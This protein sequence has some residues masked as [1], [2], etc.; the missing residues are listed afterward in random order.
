MTVAELVS[1]RGGFGLN[2]WERLN[3][4]IEEI[5][6]GPPEASIAF[7]EE[8]M[9][10]IS[11]EDL[12]LFLAGL[13]AS[14]GDILTTLMELQTLESVRAFI[15]NYVKTFY[16][17]F[18]G[19]ETLV[20]YNYSNPDYW[21]LGLIIEQASGMPF[22]EYIM[23][24][25]FEPLGMTNSGFLGISEASHRYNIHGEII[26]SE[27]VFTL[28]FATGGLVSTIYDL[29]IWLDAYFN[30]E[31]FDITRLDEIDN[32]TYNYGWIFRHNIWHHGGASGGILIANAIHD[33]ESDTTIIILSNELSTRLRLAVPQ[34]AELVLDITLLI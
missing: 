9:S 5:F 12:A 10:S 31:L 3:E 21:L 1:M 30:G 27:W 11:E 20:R 24:N 16:L 34:I 14:N 17:T 4:H 19:G 26:P 25:F 15:L 13:Q 6:L 2:N 28:S 7:V 23:T 29:N 18:W 32:N 8:F 33:R 22:E